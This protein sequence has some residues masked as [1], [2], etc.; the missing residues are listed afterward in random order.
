MPNVLPLDDPRWSE[1]Q[2]SPGGSGETA[3]MLLRQ[4][5]GNGDAEDAWTELYQQICHQN[6]FGEV[7]YAVVPHLVEI[8]KHAGNKRRMEC[9]GY[10]ASVLASALWYPESVAPVPDDLRETF[11]VA[12]EEALRLAAAELA[13][14]MADSVA[15]LELLKLVAAFHGHATIAILIEAWPDYRCQVCGEEICAENDVNYDP[16][17]SKGSARQAPSESSKEPEAKRRKWW[18]AW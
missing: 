13:K 1:L 3:A 5:S 12:K 16:G 8:A 11:E 15:S 18:R 9:L 10:I 7:A 17:P 14:P 4:L 6:S 2:A